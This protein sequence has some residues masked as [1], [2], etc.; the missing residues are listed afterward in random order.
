MQRINTVL[1]MEEE[2]PIKFDTTI[3]S[4]MFKWVNGENRINENIKFDDLW[5]LLFADAAFMSTSEEGL[6]L[7]LTTNINI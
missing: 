6:Q 3:Q 4:W 1:D 2:F 7:V 5:N